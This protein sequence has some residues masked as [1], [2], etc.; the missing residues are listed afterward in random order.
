[1]KSKEARFFSGRKAENKIG[2]FRKNN[3]GGY[4]ERGIGKKG[5]GG[6]GMIDPFLFLDHEKMGNYNVYTGG[7][8]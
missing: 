5:M 8:G 3:V 6:K 4:T 2:F 7:T 1:M